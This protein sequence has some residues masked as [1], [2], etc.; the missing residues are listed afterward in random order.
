MHIR[1]NTFLI[2]SV[3]LLSSLFVAPLPSEA[4][5]LGRKLLGA[6]FWAVGFVATLVADVTLVPLKDGALHYVR[7][8]AVRGW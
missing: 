8:P 1:I 2:A 3:F 4:K 5:G 6:P 7:K